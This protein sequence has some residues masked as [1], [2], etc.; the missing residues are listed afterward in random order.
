M[1]MLDV[2]SSGPWKE[3]EQRVQ[4][5]GGYLGGRTLEWM[6]VAFGGPKIKTSSVGPLKHGQLLR[7]RQL[8][9]AFTKEGR[10]FCLRVVFATG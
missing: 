2:G 5:G 6:N 8:G 1:V 3:G 10:N 9:S 7:Q 4:G